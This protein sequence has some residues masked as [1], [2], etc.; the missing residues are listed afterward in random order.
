MTSNEL[1]TIY[2]AYGSMVERQALRIV[3]DAHLAEDVAQEVFIAFIQYSATRKVGNVA[4]LLYQM[5]TQRAIKRIRARGQVQI[6]DAF[7]VPHGATAGTLEAWIAVRQVLQVVNST[8]AEIALH[9]FLDGMSQD[10]I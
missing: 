6:G 7:E 5:A 9:Y 8:Q 3:R 10:E 1:S 2:K 4:G